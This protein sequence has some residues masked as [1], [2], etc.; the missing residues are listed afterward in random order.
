MT[1]RLGF[2]FIFDLAAKAAGLILL[3][4]A[5]LVVIVAALRIHDEEKRRIEQLEKV[6]SPPHKCDGGT[7]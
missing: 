1:S 5:V 4:F 6:E 2:D 7:P 3:F